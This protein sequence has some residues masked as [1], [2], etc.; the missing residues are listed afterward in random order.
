M[1]SSE[2]YAAILG[3]RKSTNGG[4]RI[5]FVGGNP[6]D[7]ILDELYRN[8]STPTLCI[9]ASYLPSLDSDSGYLFVI[10]EKAFKTDEAL[11]EL[12]RVAKEGSTVFVLA[13]M[14]Y[15]IVEGEEV[16]PAGYGLE[17][18]VPGLQS[19]WSY[20]VGLMRKDTA[21]HFRS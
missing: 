21:K 12:W 9:E 5:I 1:L 10:T 13:E 3:L 4:P 15:G 6:S 8:Y 18:F 2:N 7:K 16:D 17:I 20:C 14:K 11:K 19:C